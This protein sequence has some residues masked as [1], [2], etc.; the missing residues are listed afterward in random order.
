MDYIESLKKLAGIEKEYK[1]SNVIPYDTRSIL[2]KKQ[3]EHNNGIK[4]G[5]A[6]WFDLWFNFPNKTTMTNG[7]RGL[8]K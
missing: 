6:E 1:N 8:R 3:I 5:T 2:E 7:F 4:P